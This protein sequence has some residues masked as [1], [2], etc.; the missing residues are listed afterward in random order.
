MSEKFTVSKLN[1]PVRIDR[2]LRDQYPNWGRRAVQSV[3][4][5][6]K[7]K[8]N[9]RKVWRC[10]WKVRTRDVVEVLEPPAEKPTQPSIFDEAWILANEGGLLAIN[11]PSGLL[12]ESTNRGQRANLLGLVQA[13]FGDAT[14]FHRLDRDTSGVILFTLPGDEQRALNQY[15]ARAFKARTVQK[16]YVTLVHASNQL[17]GAGE[18]KTRIDS[19][20][21]RRD[22]MEVVPRGGKLAVTHYEVE[23]DS[24]AIQRVRLWPHTGRT[25]QLRVH[26]Q[27]M[28][29]PILGDRLYGR[30]K[31]DLKSGYARLM[32]HAHRITL[33]TDGT[34]P[35]RTI[36]ALLPA[37]FL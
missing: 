9:G 2:A 31:S 32:L 4:N 14:L 19:H 18:I 15:L 20:A 7:V 28:G 33:P 35:Q 17:Q 10:S 12:S 3:I 34:F 5:A 8:V 11:K 27:H 37:E 21:D 6:G 1:Q 13:R 29:A 23:S 24:D 25:H 36:C 22:M 16:E 30:H 26:M